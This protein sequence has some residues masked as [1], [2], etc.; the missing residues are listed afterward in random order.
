VSGSQSWPSLAGNVEMVALRGIGFIGRRIPDDVDQRNWRFRSVDDNGQSSSNGSTS[1]L[2]RLARSASQTY[3]NSRGI[4]NNATVVDP[5]HGL[6]VCVL[7]PQGA[8]LQ[9]HLWYVACHDI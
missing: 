6:T 3:C 7:L 2:V 1:Y 5:G 9:T 8:E 4:I